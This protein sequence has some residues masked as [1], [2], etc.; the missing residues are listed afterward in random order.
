MYVRRDVRGKQIERSL[1]VL[2]TQGA[3][4]ERTDEIIDPTLRDQAL[5]LIAD[6]VDRSD[7]YRFSREAGFPSEKIVVGVII[8][9]MPELRD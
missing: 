4:G 1:A 2:R 5:D 8:V 7:Q 9:L 3:P 6:C